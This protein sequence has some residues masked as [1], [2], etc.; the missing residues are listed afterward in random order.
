[1]Q[2]EILTKRYER[3]HEMITLDQQ[4]ELRNKRVCIIGCGG[5]GGYSIEF[6]ARLGVGNMTVVDG[7]VFDETN[8]NRQVLSN[9]SNIGKSKAEIALHHIHTINSDVNVTAISNFFAEDNAEA[10][11]KEH[12]VVVDAL[13]N[14]S[15]RRLLEKTCATL[16]IPF[17]HG[18]I[19]GWYGQVATIFPGDQ[20]LDSIYHSTGEKGVEKR[21][22]NP[23]FTPAIVSGIQVSEVLKIMLGSPDVLRH[24]VLYIDLLTHS[25]DILQVNDNVTLV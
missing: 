17:V 12:D 24:K 2:D 16:N 19:A 18:A 3:N 1:M 11:L 6:L 21:L 20:T 10:I 4:Q 14:I 5:L 23:S 8:L 9:E 22:G 13:D 15:T 7:D 25:Y